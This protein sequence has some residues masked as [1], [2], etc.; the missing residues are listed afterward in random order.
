MGYNNSMWIGMIYY[1]NLYPLKYVLNPT[2]KSSLATIIWGYL[3]NKNEMLNDMVL[4]KKMKFHE[5]EDNMVTTIK[6]SHLRKPW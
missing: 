4:T 2:N 5:R 6:Y 3:R 1:L